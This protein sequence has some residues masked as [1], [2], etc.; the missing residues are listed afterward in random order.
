MS[1]RHTFRK[2]R[3]LLL[4]AFLALAGCGQRNPSPVATPPLVVLTATPVEREVV[5]YDIFTARTQAT[6]SV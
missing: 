2:S 4:A 3:S 6:Q 5:D 1:T